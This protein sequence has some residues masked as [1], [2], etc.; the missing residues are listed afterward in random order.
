MTRR[1]TGTRGS[2]TG[3][4]DT[5]ARG[6]ERHGSARGRRGAALDPVLQ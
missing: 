3:T 1:V 6:G 2:V 5:A 4:R